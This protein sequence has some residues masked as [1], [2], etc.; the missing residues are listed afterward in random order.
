MPFAL[1]AFEYWLAVYRRVWRG[2]LAS[3]LINPVLY[4]T[5]LGVGLG[6]IVNRG[7]N[8]ALGMPYLDFVAPGMLAAVAMQ[9]ASVESSFPVTGA[10][11]W[12]RQYWAMLATPLRIAD[13][14]GGHLL[15]VTTRVAVSAS[16]Y[17]AAISAFG[18]VHS[19]LAVLGIPLC[20]LIGLAFAG[21]I[22]ALAAWAEEEVFNP[23]FRFGIMPMFL[24]SGS[25][26]PV[27]RLPHGLRELAYATPLW[28][29]VDLMRHLT[30]GTATLGWSALHVAYLT[31][32]AV[33]G[34]WLA[35]AAYRKKLVT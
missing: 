15:Y 1:R 9:V 34:V 13:L 35:R 30:L 10:I 21:P 31:L 7:G 8:S 33:G 26:F 19:P 18:A 23:L 24:F 11:K 25:F 27:T 3:S 17:L 29:G 32:W 20:M 5:A 14:V 6:K 2:T 16:L 12:G 4:L 28:H 22:S